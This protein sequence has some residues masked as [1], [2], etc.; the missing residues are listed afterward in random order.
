MENNIIIESLIADVVHK[1]KNG[2]GG[3]GG[4]A[5]LLER[6]VDLSETNKRFIKRIIDGVLSV[7]DISVKLMSLVRAREIHLDKVKIHYLYREILKNISNE[8]EELLK[9]F[10]ISSKYPDK[11]V[12]IEGD[13]DILSE[14]FKNILQF[15]FSIEAEINS[16]EINPSKNSQIAIDISLTKKIDRN[17]DFSSYL[18]NII[19]STRYLESRLS[20]AIFLKMLIIHDGIL[21]IKSIDNNTHLIK[22]EI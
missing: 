7:N 20:Y 8:N 17:D 6:D 1:I 13:N 3:I 16:I 22:F 5:T 14:L 11:K 2:L 21:T 19:N 15:L 18:Q 9:K 4:F 12:E 10:I